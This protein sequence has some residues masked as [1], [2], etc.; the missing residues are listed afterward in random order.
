MRITCILLSVWSAGIIFS[1]SSGCTTGERVSRV[2]PWY[3]EI[4]H[5]YFEKGQFCTCT[6]AI[7]DVDLYVRGK[8]L[9]LLLHRGA[10]LA[11][12]CICWVGGW[13]GTSSKFSPLAV[14]AQR[15]SYQKQPALP[16][17]YDDLCETWK[18]KQ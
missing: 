8:T 13:S 6:C 14:S 7:L 10:D 2:L 15:D 16:I 4:R 5:L 1:K 17:I 3:E 11:S 9:C 18:E 12:C